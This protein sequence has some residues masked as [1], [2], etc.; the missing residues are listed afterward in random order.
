MLTL[1]SN[2]TTYIYNFFVTTKSLHNSTFSSFNLSMFTEEV[3]TTINYQDRK[4]F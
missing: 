3:G 2:L 1:L 4:E